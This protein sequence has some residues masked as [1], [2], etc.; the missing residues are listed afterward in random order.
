M[1]YVSHTPEDRKKMLATVGVA[2]TEELF[3]DLPSSLR[4]PKMNI[5]PALSELELV[6]HMKD[7]TEL[8]KYPVRGGDYFIGGGAYNH[9]IPQAAIQMVGRSEFY[10]AYTPYQPEISQG[11]LQA[12]FE[13]QTAIARITDMDV[14]NASLYDGGTAVYEACV[15]ALLQTRRNRVV[16]DTSLHPNYREVLQTCSRNAKIEIDC[17]PY[18]EKEGGNVKNLAA[19]VDDQTAAVIVQYPDFFGRVADFS[20]LAAACHAKKALLVMVVNPLALGVLKTPGQMD[21]DIVIGEGQSLGMPLS[22]GG[23][24]LGF[25]AAKESFSR[26]MPGR[27][28]GETVDKEGRRGFVLTLQAREQHIKRERATSNICSNQALCALQALAYVTVMGKQGF[29]DVSELCMQKA[30][31]ARKTLS[32]V[33]GAQLVFSGPHFHEFVLRLKKPVMDLFRRFGHAF[34]PGI[35]LNRW[36]QE[37]DDCLLVAVT[38]VNRKQDIDRYAQRL[39]EWLAD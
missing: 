5:P 12:I 39:G 31:Y 2:S 16:M 1:S 18:D 3:A 26:K 24:Y 11:M 32:A 30:A 35:R 33:D 6:E 7:L 21:A 8:N 38:E 9:H 28:V 10:T 25:M 36:Y 19:K 4:N 37:L 17:L 29:R 34:E 27:L 15:V 22:Y 14:S 23:P 13:Y 20:E